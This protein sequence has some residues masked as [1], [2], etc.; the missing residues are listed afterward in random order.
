[1]KNENLKLFAEYLEYEKLRGHTEQGFND[2]R[3][4]T[5]RFIEY[6]D[7]CGLSVNEVRV[8]DASGFQGWLIGRKLKNTT[9]ASYV[10]PASA[11]CEFL[12]K[13]GVIP[14]N[15]FKM[16]RRV[17]PEKHI[18]R[19]I[20]KEQQMER[21]LDFLARFN[22][23]GD[24]KARKRAY[25]A[26]VVAELMYSTGL[27]ASEVAGL[28]VSDID[29]G[30]GIVYVNHGK[31]GESRIAWLGDY[32]KA[33]LRLYMTRMR[34][35]LENEWNER[36]GEL[37]FGVKW[38]CFGR[39]INGPLGKAARKC[40]LAGF[41]SHGFRHAV[42][43]HL[44]RAGCNIRYI[45]EILGHKAL[46]NTEIYTKVDRDDLKNILDKCHPRQWSRK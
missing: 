8:R 13:K 31:G 6:L 44:L 37:L 30:K 14:S 15:P 43:Y 21:L 20:P 12:R 22:E 4:R 10:I 23:H 27:R 3:V 35:L 45:Q 36:N 46:H 9:V 17:Q 25:R 24:L 26:H 5:P 2:I 1:M 41:T 16:I 32:A 34:R 42:G 39:A 40:R 19:S 33:V 11:F 7:E 18:P 28:K 29:F 38:S